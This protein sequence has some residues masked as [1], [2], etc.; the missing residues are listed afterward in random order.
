MD[1]QNPAIHCML[2]LKERSSLP[3]SERVAARLQEIIGCGCQL[4]WDAPAA[5]EDGIHAQNYYFEGFPVLVCLTPM[6]IPWAELEGPC[7]ENDLWPEATDVCRQHQAHLVIGLLGEPD[8]IPGHLMLTHFAAAMA[9]E[10]GALAVYWGN[11]GVVQPTE[12]FC[13]LAADAWPES[14][15]LML[16]VSFHKF[17]YDGAPFV[18][19]QGL[20]AF[21]LMEVEGGSAALPPKQLLAHV[22]DIAH[23]LCVQGPV[24]KDGDTVGSNAQ[25]RFPVKYLPSVVDQSRNAIRILFDEPQKPRGL[26]SRLWK[27]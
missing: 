8:P 20:D 4:T 17:M 27:H 3:D 21:G 25:E 11:G 19:T 15:P 14:L 9:M 5:S 23:Y 13:R 2:L 26:F 1:E 10:A 7:A 18:A 24:L 22:F 16:W 6:P 12:L